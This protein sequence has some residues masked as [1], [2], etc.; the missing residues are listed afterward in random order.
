MYAASQGHKDTVSLLKYFYAG[1]WNNDKYTA[2]MYCARSNVS[3]VA[4]QLIPYEVGMKNKITAI[5]E[6]IIYDSDKPMKELLPYK[7]EYVSGLDY[8]EL[9]LDREADK[10]ARL[11]V[12]NNP[13]LLN[14]SGQSYLA[15][16][17]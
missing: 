16:A 11:L 8:Y 10:C 13:T 14:R 4:A 5:Y 12:Q 9:C 2:L 15:I 17:A 7:Q 1:R 3:G 6:C